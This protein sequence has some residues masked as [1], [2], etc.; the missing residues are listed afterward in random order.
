MIVL[1]A[2]TN[3]TK[4]VIYNFVDSLNKTGFDGRKIV[5]YYNPEKSIVNYLE[6]QGWEVLTYPKPKYYINFQR[7]KEFSDIIVEYNLEDEHICCTDMKDV[8]F[9]KPIS[10]IK[11][12]LYVQFDTSLTFENHEWNRK[13]IQKGYPEYYNKLKDK[14]PFCSGVIIGKGSILKEF[15]DDFYST[16]LC[17][18]FENIQDVTPGL[19]QSTFNLLLY[20]KYRFR[21]TSEGKYVLHMSNLDD[22]FNINNYHIY[23]QYERREK[24]QVFVDNLNK[25]SYI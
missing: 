19:D 2:L 13:T 6:K 21:W 5:A 8:Y 25:K 20:T 3:Y 15:F 24:H 16:G 18:G 12:N 9:A 11:V 14:R 17:S 1:T 4:D 23:H 22:N 10:D 7:R